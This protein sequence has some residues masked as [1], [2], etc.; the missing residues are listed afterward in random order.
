MQARVVPAASC[1]RLVA[2][3]VLSTE[4]R[5][6]TFQLA[7]YWPPASDVAVSSSCLTGASSE[8]ALAR[9]AAPA[10]MINLRN[11]TLPL[12]KILAQLCVALHSPTRFAST[13][14]FMFIVSIGLLP[15]DA[16]VIAIW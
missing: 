8:Q 13:F 15:L 11:V 4:R 5:S 10:T 14:I 2:G 6:V 3:V 16:T 9:I 1:F 7:S 12:R